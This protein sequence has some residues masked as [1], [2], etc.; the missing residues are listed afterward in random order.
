MKTFILTLAVLSLT[1]MALSAAVKVKVDSRNDRIELKSDNLPISLVQ[2][3]KVNGSSYQ[4]KILRPSP[5]IN[6]E[7]SN[8]STGVYMITVDD[9][10]GERTLEF[11]N[12]N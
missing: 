2:L 1:S 11:V 4:S 3:F 8:L 9:I 6:L 12:I 7:I 10:Q 5:E